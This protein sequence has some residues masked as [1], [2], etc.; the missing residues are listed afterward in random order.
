MPARKNA[1]PMRIRMMHIKDKQAFAEKDGMM[2]LLGKPIDV[3]KSW[4]EEGCKLIHIVDNDA[5]KGSPTNLDIYDNLTFFVNVQVECA[6]AMPMVMKFLSLKC[7]VVLPLSAGPSIGAMVEKKLLV[8]K[9]SGGV[10]GE[11]ELASFHDVVLVD[12]DDVSVARY[13]KLGKRVMIYDKD[14]GKVK[15]EMKSVWGIISIS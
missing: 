8:A 11:A 6:P 13:A 5:L 9:I 1:G 3:A 2:R 14:K 12:A 15:K 10:P 7:R 4:K